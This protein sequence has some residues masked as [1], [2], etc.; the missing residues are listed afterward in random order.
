MSVLD[1]GIRA[2][3]L[4]QLKRFLEGQRITRGQALKAKCYDCMGGYA[5]GAIDCGV[6]S[7]PLYPYMPYGK[8][9]KKAKFNGS[10]PI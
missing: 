9:Q 10:P 3:G 8:S 4:T 5:D 6:E 7:C 1:I 2:K